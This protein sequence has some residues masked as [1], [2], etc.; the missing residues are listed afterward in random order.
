MNVRRLG[1]SAVRGQDQP[2]LPAT[3]NRH[4]V[5]AGGLNRRLSVPK[6]ASPLLC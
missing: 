2:R 1:M 5:R 3:I 6:P 4:R